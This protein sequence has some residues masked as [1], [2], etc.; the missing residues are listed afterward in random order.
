MKDTQSTYTSSLQLKYTHASIVTR[1]N[2]ASGAYISYGKGN[3]GTSGLDMPFSA[4]GV[5]RYVTF[6]V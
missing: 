6:Q 3:T 2:G 4:T 1:F 5:L